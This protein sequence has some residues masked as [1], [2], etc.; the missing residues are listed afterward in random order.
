M[1]EDDIGLARGEDRFHAAQNAGRDLREALVGAHD[2]E[3][4][5]GRDRKQFEQVV[6]HLAV[7]R[8]DADDRLDLR[9]ARGERFDHRR[10]LDRIG[11]GPEDRHDAKR[12]RHFFCV[13]TSPPMCMRPRPPESTNAVAPSTNA[14]A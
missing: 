1:N 3:I 12:P 14:T 11:P 5:V 4:E 6:E 13:Q 2:I 10:H 9:T 8:G 7:L